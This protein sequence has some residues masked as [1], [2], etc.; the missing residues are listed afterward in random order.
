MESPPS[1][2]YIDSWEL[3]IDGV[4]GGG[5]EDTLEEHSEGEEGGRELDSFVFRGE[6]GTR[7]VH[8]LD[9]NLTAKG[10]LFFNF[11]TSS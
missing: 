2:E 8:S 4:Q 10:F 11:S 9:F 1:M 7:E 3:G 5:E 6:E